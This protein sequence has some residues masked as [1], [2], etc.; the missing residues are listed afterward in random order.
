MYFFLSYFCDNCYTHYLFEFN[1]R[2]DTVLDRSWEVQPVTWSQLTWWDPMPCGQILMSHL[3]HDEFS[4]Y[5][6]SPAFS[7]HNNPPTPQKRRYNYFHCKTYNEFFNPKKDS[8][9]N[10]SPIKHE[11]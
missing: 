5:L 6:P 11:N 7:M 4:I 3:H 9:L 2:L 10:V 1:Y 8:I